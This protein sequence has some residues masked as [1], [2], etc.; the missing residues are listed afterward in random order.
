RALTASRIYHE[1]NTFFPHLDGDRFEAAYRSYLRRVLSTGDRREFDLASMELVATL[2]DGHTWFYDKWLDDNFG[3][4][5]GFFAFPAG[6]QWAVRRSQL[7]SIRVGD[8][9]TAVDGVPITDFFAK[10]RRY[11]S[12]SGDRDAELSLFL[13]PPVFP[14]KFTVTL[15][16]G[17]KVTV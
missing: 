1:V 8:V 5:L 17:R 4:A 6:K 3:Q 16:D 15:A 11:I 10:Q 13:T 9:V 14:L 2:H 7:D 12:S